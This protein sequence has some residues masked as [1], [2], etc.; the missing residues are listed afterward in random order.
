[1]SPNL[2]RRPLWQRTTAQS[3]PEMSITMSSASSITPFKA[4]KHA[5]PISR[6]AEHAGDRELA[7]FFREVQA[8]Y[9]QL[10]DRSKT[11]LRQRLR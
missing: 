8:T 2:E 7:Q 5:P 6:D 4:L 11:L 9:R 3:A 10:C 1:M